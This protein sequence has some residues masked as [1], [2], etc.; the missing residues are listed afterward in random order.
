MCISSVNMAARP[1][2]WFDSKQDLNDATHEHLRWSILHH[3][4]NAGIEVVANVHSESPNLAPYTTDHP[5]ASEYMT[6]SLATRIIFFIEALG[7]YESGWH[8]VNDFIDPYPEPVRLEDCWGVLLVHREDGVTLRIGDVVSYLCDHFHQSSI[9]DK[10]LEALV[11][12]RNQGFDHINNKGIWWRISKVEMRTL[13]LDVLTQGSR[14][15]KT[16]VSKKTRTTTGRA[17]DF[18]PWRIWY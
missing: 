17:S 15:S 4:G 1:V 5:I 11:W 18:G 10:I 8:D 13:C 12:M 3:A 6:K 16:K 9:K 2:P 7:E 14:R